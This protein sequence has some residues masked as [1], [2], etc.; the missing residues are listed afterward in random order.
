MIEAT[1]EPSFDIYARIIKPAIERSLRWIGDHPHVRS[2][3]E[4]EAAIRKTM[5]KE[6]AIELNYARRRLNQLRTQ[7][8][9]IEVLA[10]GE[11]PPVPEPELVPSNTGIG[12]PYSSGVYFFWHDGAVRYVGQAKQL[13]K[14]VRMGVH[15][16]LRNG[17]KISWV[18][19][20]FTVLDFA[21]AFYIGTLRPERNFG[22]LAKWKEGA[23]P[24]R[25]ETTA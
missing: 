15:H 5:R 20:P 13:R 16:A 4:E 22:S 19:I 14:R 11:Y 24:G 18:E 6:T 9:K 8:K 2:A 7:I 10:F 12:L 25:K 17:D 21:E 23:Q 1:C 3:A